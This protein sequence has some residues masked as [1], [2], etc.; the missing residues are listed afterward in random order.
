MSSADL[1]ARRLVEIVARTRVD[2]RDPAPGLDDLRWVL[3]RINRALR[4]GLHALLLIALGA[5]PQ[6]R[7][8]RQDLFF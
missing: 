6:R 1:Q 7:R 2:Y 4:H 8:H 3:R 5:R